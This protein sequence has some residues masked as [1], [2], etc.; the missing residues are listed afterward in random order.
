MSLLGN[1]WIA[2]GFCLA[3]FFLLGTLHI[4]D[5]ISCLNDLWM[6]VFTYKVVDLEGKKDLEATKLIY[7]EWGK[8]L[9]QYLRLTLNLY[10]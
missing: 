5:F 1:T 7:M 9:I 2:V 3:F 4:F 6:S 10:F 8:I